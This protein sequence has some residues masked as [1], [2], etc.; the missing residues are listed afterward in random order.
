[1]LSNLLIWAAVSKSEVYLLKESV[2]SGQ[3]RSPLNFGAA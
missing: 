2:L 1:M 3:V